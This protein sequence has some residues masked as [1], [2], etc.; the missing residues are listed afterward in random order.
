[1][2]PPWPPDPVKKQ[3]FGKH[4]AICKGD[5]FADLKHLL[6]GRGQLRLPGDTRFAHPPTL[7]ASVGE[8][9]HSPFPGSC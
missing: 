9:A 1:M 5:S 3:Q 8:F 7:Q 6:E 4:L 2:Q